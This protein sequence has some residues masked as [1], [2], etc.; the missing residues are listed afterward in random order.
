M[1]RTFNYILST[2][3]VI[4]LVMG[5][6][7][8]SVLPALIHDVFTIPTAYAAANPTC[9]LSIAPAHS[10]HSGEGF[11]FEATL[12]NAGPD[13][14]FSPFIELVTPD[15]I[16][17]N[18]SVFSIGSLALTPVVPTPTL[19]IDNDGG[20]PLLG[21][22][23]N[24]LTNATLLLP[25]GS[26]Y[27]AYRLPVGSFV[28]NQTEVAAVFSATLSE[29]PP[30]EVPLANPIQSRCG[31][32]L[33]S[34]PLDNPNVD[35][36][37]YSALQDSIITPTLI[38]ASKT[39]ATLHGEGETAT[40]ENYPVNYTIS[41]DIATNKTITDIV[42]TDSISTDLIVTSI[43]GQTASASTITF[44]PLVGPRKFSPHLLLFPLL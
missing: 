18:S 34:D 40:G 10:V 20:D 15:Y 14:G 3:L 31:F 5:N 43:T 19:V 33:G 36:P 1:K 4:S 24:P 26:T 44:T 27:R 17:L 23:T 13:T 29:I 35:P 12:G 30:I 9:A 38:T 8:E 37:L 39:L 42:L 28:Q 16:T 25:V 7:V 6:I 21:T 2:F 22:V 11:T 32:S 41:A